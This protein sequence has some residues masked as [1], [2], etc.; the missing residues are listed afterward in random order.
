M[1]DEVMVA[2][3][4]AAVATS[5]RLLRATDVQQIGGIS[6]E[7]VARAG[8]RQAEVQYGGDVLLE[9]YEHVLAGL[10]L[11]VKPV[12]GE[13]L[14]SGGRVEELRSLVSG[15]VRRR[16]LH[17]V[18]P[19]GHGGG[20][21]GLG[22]WRIRHRLRRGRSCGRRRWNGRGCIRRLVR[23]LGRIHCGGSPAR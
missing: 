18:V 8:P 2:P 6:L 10:S 23:R 7:L 20:R 12:E 15:N 13:A 11:V 19:L 3:S 9:E 4:I 16:A 1:N 14:W 17:F 22:C 5:H 21:S